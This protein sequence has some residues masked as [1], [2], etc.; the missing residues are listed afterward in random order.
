MSLKEQMDLEQYR[1]NALNKIYQLR[2]QLSSIAKETLGVEDVMVMP[3]GSVTDPNKFTE[4]SDIDVGFFLSPQASEINEQKS[5]VLQQ[6]LLRF[7]INDIGI[8][9]SIVFE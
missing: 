5:W 1:Q 9:N 2:D 6:A 8:V 4:D 3:I 7:P